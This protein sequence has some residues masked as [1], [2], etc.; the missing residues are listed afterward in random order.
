MQQ[1]RTLHMRVHQSKFPPIMFYFTEMVA[2]NIF[3]IF[4]KCF[5]EIYFDI[6]FTVTLYNTN[7][8]FQSNTNFSESQYIHINLISTVS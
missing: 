7:L 4:F 8:D 5:L 3:C 1:F 2:N 6:V